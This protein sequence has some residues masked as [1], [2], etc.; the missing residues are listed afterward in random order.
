MFRL[1]RSGGFS[2]TELMIVVAIMAILLTIAIPN[3][4]NFVM[5][6]KESEAIGNLSGI[7]IGEYSYKAED[8]RYHTCKDSPA[9]TN[10]ARPVPWVDMGTPGKDAFVDIGFEPDG[11]VRYRYGVRVGKDRNHFNATARGDLDE[12]GKHETFRLDTRAADYP[13]VRRTEQK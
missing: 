10:G 11:N 6:V 3:Y 5:K 1:S 7:R 12:D 4:M 8:G 2:L 9:M 13:K